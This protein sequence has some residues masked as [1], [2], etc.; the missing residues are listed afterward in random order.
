MKTTDELKAFQK[1]KSYADEYT[2]AIDEI[3]LFDAGYGFLTDAQGC[4]YY[5]KDLE[6]GQSI[7]EL[8]DSLADIESFLSNK[9]NQGVKKAYSYQGVKSE[10]AF[11]DLENGMKL[12]VTAPDKQIFASANKIQMVI[13]GM[14]LHRRRSWIFHQRQRGLHCGSVPMRLVSWQEKFTRCVRYCMK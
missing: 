13:F 10:L 6:M 5:H 12:I 2:D 9:E 4:V 8:D 14:G 1:N 11:Y 3:R 7:S